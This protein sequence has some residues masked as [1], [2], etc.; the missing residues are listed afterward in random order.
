MFKKPQPIK[1]QFLNSDGNLDAI[2]EVFKESWQ[3]GK[4]AQ[5]R[6]A[7]V[8]SLT[9]FLIAAESGNFEKSKLTAIKNSTTPTYMLEIKKDGFVIRIDIIEKK[10]ETSVE[11]AV[12]NAALIARPKRA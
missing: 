4:Y 6:L 1:I 3:G 7:L 11:Y 2:C 9:K 8:N 5:T 12:C 10:G